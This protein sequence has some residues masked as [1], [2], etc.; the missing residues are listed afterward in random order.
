MNKLFVEKIFKLSSSW[1]K[2]FDIETQVLQTQLTM[3]LT[4]THAP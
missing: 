4:A 1:K 2:C 3:D